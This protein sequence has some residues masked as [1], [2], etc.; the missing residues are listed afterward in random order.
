VAL[1]NSMELRN[2]F[3]FSLDVIEVRLTVVL[4]VLS[5]HVFPLLCLLKYKSTYGSRE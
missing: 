1:I 3:G 5:N 2:A 4:V